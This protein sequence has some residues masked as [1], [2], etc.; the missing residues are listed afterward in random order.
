M[1][2]TTPFRSIR[3]ATAQRSALIVLCIGIISACSSKVEEKKEPEEKTKA[4]IVSKDTIKPVEVTISLLAGFWEYSE[5]RTNPK[6]SGT[7]PVGE[8][9]L[10]IT[11][12][13][14]LTFATNGIKELKENLEM[15]PTNFEIRGNTLF[16]KDKLAIGD[17]KISFNNI[18]TTVYLLNENE[19]IL[20]KGVLE[21]DTPVLYMYFTRKKRD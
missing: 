13:N 11:E 20:G 5:V 8:I 3:K 9:L 18:K 17:F 6:E 2:N 14:E 10:G 15:I 1:N 21:K 7:P 19:L 12:K 4:V 16:P